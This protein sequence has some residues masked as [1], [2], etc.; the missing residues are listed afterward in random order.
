VFHGRTLVAGAG[1]EPTT[2]R[3]LFKNLTPL[4]GIAICNLFGAFTVHFS[5]L[6]NYSSKSRRKSAEKN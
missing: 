6:G 3:F 2:F 1:F 4:K 5:I